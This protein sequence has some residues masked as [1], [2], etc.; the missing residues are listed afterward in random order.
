MITLLTVC[1]TVEPNLKRNHVH[2]SSHATKTRDILIISFEFTHGGPRLYHHTR[3]RDNTQRST[4][5]LTMP[6]EDRIA[7]WGIAIGV[8]RPPPTAYQLT[9]GHA[10]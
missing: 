10:P 7:G 5:A 8:R 9:R 3:L 1:A 4:G 6:T 2:D